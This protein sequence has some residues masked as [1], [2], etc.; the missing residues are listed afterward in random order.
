MSVMLSHEIS[1]L[2]VANAKKSNGLNLFLRMKGRI[3]EQGMGRLFIISSSSVA[4][5]LQ[6]FKNNSL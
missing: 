4:V 6:G 2:R 5:S 1:K 3:V